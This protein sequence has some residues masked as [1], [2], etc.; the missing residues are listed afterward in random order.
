MTEIYERLQDARRKAGYDTAKD[1]ADAFGWNEVTYRSHEAGDR[2]VRQSVA[3]KYAKAL[4]V[5]VVW[6]ITGQGSPDKGTAE[7]VDIWS[8]IP[9]AD[10]PTARRLLESLAKNIEG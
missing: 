3:E 7:I 1:A 2:G 6:L 4:R 8:R 9:D 10:Q 5:S